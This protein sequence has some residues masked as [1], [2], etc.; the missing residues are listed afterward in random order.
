M[1]VLWKEVNASFVDLEL[2]CRIVL[3]CFELL[4]LKTSLQVG[5]C[6]PSTLSLQNVKS[7][8]G[9]YLYFVRIIP[10]FSLLEPARLSRCSNFYCQ[11]GWLYDFVS[12][13]IC[14][15]LSQGFDQSVPECILLWNSNYF[16]SLRT[17]L[18]VLELMGRDVYFFV[19]DGGW[20]YLHHCSFNVNKKIRS[21]FL[22]EFIGRVR[23]QLCLTCKWYHTTGLSEFICILGCW[24]RMMLI[25]AILVCFSVGSSCL[26]LLLCP[27]WWFL[28]CCS[29]M[30]LCRWVFT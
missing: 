14:C 19:H 28:S 9:I 1:A 24:W 22:K 21:S 23:S 6:H 5:L 8:I 16:F 10:Y 17:M 13:I 26:Y 25:R 7:L 15:P 2:R 12:C 3:S 11:L 29:L 18:Q 30:K 20:W 4:C 27:C